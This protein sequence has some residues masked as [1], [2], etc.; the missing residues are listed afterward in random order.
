MKHMTTLAAIL[1]I[2]GAM[3]VGNAARAEDKPAKI[4]A[5]IK[6]QEL[7]DLANSEE[8]KRKRV[9]RKEARRL[10]ALEKEKILKQKQ[11]A[12]EARCVIKPAMSDEEIAVCREVRTKP[13]P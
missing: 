1:A 12:W 9:E 7:T 4:E 13:A 2:A 5:D 11:Q 8:E 3:A 10:A 6:K